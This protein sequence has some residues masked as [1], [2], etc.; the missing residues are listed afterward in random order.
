MRKKKERT[1]VNNPIRYRGYY[2]DFETGFYYLQSRYYDPAV[3]RFINADG[4]LF[5][6]TNMLGYNIYSYCINNPVNM[7]DSTGQLPKWIKAIGDFFYNIGDAF[8]RSIEAQIGVGF[9]IGG[10]VSDNVTVE[11]SRDTYVGIDDGVLVTGNVITMEASLLGKVG[12]GDSYN[13]LVEKDFVRVSSSGRASDG[14]FDMLYYPDVVKESSLVIGP[15]EIN[16][17]GEFLI[18]VGGSV[19]LGPGGHVK[20][21]F[22]ITEFLERLLD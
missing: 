20:A 19:H 11:I 6:E 22:N 7:Y 10:S 1:W 21:A 13:H 18:S 12:V 4:Y 9:G 14:P 5:S 3:R 2:Q 15:F 8:L 16:N 17:E